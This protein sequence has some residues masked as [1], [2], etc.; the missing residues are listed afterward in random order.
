MPMPDPSSVPAPRADAAVPATYLPMAPQP[1]ALLHQAERLARLGQP[2]WLPGEV[3]GRLADKL[4]AIRLTPVDWVDWGGFLG[5]GAADV[6]RRYPQAQRWVIEPTPALAER[7]RQTWQ[8]AHPRRWWAA[9]ARREATPPV[10]LAGQP[11]P[12][13]TP[14]I[15]PAQGAGLVWANMSLHTHADPE[16]MMRQWHGLLAVDGFVMCSGLGP[17]SAQ[18]LRTVYRQMGWPWPTVQFVDMHDL[19]DALANAGFAEPVM[20]MERLTL[21]WVDAPAML[22]ELRT[23]GGNVAWGR[24]QGCRTPRWR[25]R[26]LQAIDTHC[27]LKDGRVGLTLELIYGHAIK[28]LPRVPVSGESRVSVDDLKRIIKSGGKQAL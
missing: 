26:L 27:R 25:E 16:A 15:W 8:A 3:A 1:A 7:S 10:A 11:W 17:D 24:F 23:W 18:E 28:P 20:D 14:S 12:A 21:T 5:Q 2:A 22:A 13:D 9:L 4:D 19:G 6:A